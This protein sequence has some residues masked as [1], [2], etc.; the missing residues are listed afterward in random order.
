MVTVV[1]PYAGD[2]PHRA[3]ALA[4]VLERYATAHPAWRVVVATDPAAGPWCKAAAVMP[5]VEAAEDGVV[6]VADADCWTDRLSAAVA[7]VDAGAPWAMPH[8][9]VRRLD[10]VGTVAVIA[11]AAWDA[12]VVAEQPYDGVH[13][14]GFVVA[15][16][17][18][19]LRVPIDARFVG[20]GNEDESWAIAL[21]ATVGEPWRGQAD[22]VHLWHPP[23][24]RWTRRRGSPA[25]WKLRRRYVRAAGDSAVMAALIEEARDAHQPALHAGSPLAVGRD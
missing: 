4:W 15:R 3:A 22:L 8:R 25:S 21:T 5:A 23:Q 10:E 14:G 16:R 11:G 1:I 20:W 12:A 18:T 9:L 24:A 19:L 6:I 2:C 7:A 17:E 13:G